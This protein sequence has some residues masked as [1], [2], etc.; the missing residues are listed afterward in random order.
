[1]LK[2]KDEL[3]RQCEMAWKR[4]RDFGVASGALVTILLVVLFKIIL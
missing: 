3:L 2:P 1:M 4:G